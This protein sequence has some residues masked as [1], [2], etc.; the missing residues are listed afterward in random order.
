MY[1]TWRHPSS[2]GLQLWETHFG[3]HLPGKIS[4][5]QWKGL[6][7]T[8][9]ESP[10]D[11]Q[12]GRRFRRWSISKSGHL[13]IWQHKTC[14]GTAPRLPI[15]KSP[16]GSKTHSVVSPPL[17]STDWINTSKRFSLSLFRTEWVTDFTSRSSEL[18]VVPWV[19]LWSLRDFHKRFTNVWRL[20]RNIKHWHSSVLCPFSSEQDRNVH[21][22][23]T[24]REF[25]QKL[26]NSGWQAA[27]VELVE[28][29]YSLKWWLVPQCLATLSCLPYTLYHQWS[30]TDLCRTQY[31][32]LSQ[33][34]TVFIQRNNYHAGQKVIVN[35]F[36]SLST[37]N[38]PTQVS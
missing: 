4:R 20:E 6:Q 15:R 14:G 37:S 22:H 33:P 17:L 16:F 23:S 8:E 26:K 7:H 1:E 30:L 3:P 34:T 25:L 10:A 18:S 19:S 36:N 5:L 32:H 24:I 21:K 11:V 31:V 29:D 28:V 38:N 13:Q 2:E 12:H 35:R 9:V 27:L